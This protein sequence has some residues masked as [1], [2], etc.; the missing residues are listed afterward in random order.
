[1]VE[2]VRGA[3]AGQFPVDDGDDCLTV[4]GAHVEDL[5]VP[6][7]LRVDGGIWSF[8]STTPCSGERTR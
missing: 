8:I 7:K 4:V 2:L 6:L 3:V 5:V 1:M